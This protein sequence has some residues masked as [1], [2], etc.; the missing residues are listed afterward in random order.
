[1]GLRAA[2]DDLRKETVR[3]DTEHAERMRVYRFQLNSMN[4]WLEL[5]M[6]SDPKMLTV[7]SEME[8]DGTVN[9]IELDIAGGKP[10]RIYWDENAMRVLLTNAAPDG[11]G[12]SWELGYSPQGEPIFRQAV[13]DTAGF[14][15]QAVFNPTG[16][17]DVVADLAL[18]PRSRLTTR[19]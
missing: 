8:S 17:F 9:R 1:M 15:L 16:L 7:T 19:H 14:Y 18:A 13:S 4:R 2:I 12:E 5:E 3:R 6:K 10:V 11:A